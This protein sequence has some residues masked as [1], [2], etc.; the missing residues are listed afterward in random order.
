MSTTLYIQEALTSL[1][2]AAAAAINNREW[3]TVEVLGRAAKDLHAPIAHVAPITASEIELMVNTGMI[4]CVKA[5]RARRGCTLK[6]AKKDMDDYA[7]ARGWVRSQGRYVPQADAPSEW[8]PKL[9][10]EDVE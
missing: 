5:I 7:Y 9:A 2:N 3:G 8:T 10:D 1:S 4:E 6:E